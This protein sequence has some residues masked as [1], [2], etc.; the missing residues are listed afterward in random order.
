MYFPTDLMQL[1]T[2]SMAGPLKSWKEFQ[3]QHLSQNKRTEVFTLLRAPLATSEQTWL[4]LPDLWS[5]FDSF[6][7][8]SVLL[9]FC[10]ANNRM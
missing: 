2:L 1:E 6:D 7:A 10:K 4:R 8:A 5:F 9:R 3:H